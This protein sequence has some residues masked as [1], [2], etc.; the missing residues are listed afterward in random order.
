MSGYS[1]LL[2][3]VAGMMVFS[4]L[5]INTSRNYNST[6]QNIYRSE[7][8]YRAI[9]VAQDEI[10]KVQW[11]YDD[12]DLDPNSPNYVY[13]DHPLFESQSYGA[14]DQ[15]TDNFYV[16]AESTLIS[17]NGSEKRYQVTV[18]VLYDDVDP[19]IFI[20]LDYTKSYSY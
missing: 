16:Y 5:A 15:Y 7:V 6:R 20:T 17:D 19:D 4:I 11:I 18:S 9:A 10:D 2:Y 14:N 12:N 8:E 1:E 13:A 3:L